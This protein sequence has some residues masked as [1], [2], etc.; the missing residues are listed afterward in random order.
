MISNYTNHLHDTPLDAAFT[1]AQWNCRLICV[2]QARVCAS[3]YLTVGMWVG[4]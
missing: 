2:L 4:L 1:N 3:R